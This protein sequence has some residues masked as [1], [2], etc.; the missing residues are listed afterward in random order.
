VIARIAPPANAFEPKTLAAWRRWRQA[1]SNGSKSNKERI[2]Q[3]GAAFEARA[4]SR[5]LFQAF[6]RS[7]QRGI[8]ECIASAKRPQTRAKRVAETATLAAINIPVNLW[9]KR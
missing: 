7:T 2:L 9:P 3:L 4:A 8:L 5:E 1:R 6:P